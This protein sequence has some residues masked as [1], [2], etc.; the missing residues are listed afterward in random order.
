ML[1][2]ITYSL[3]APGPT[4]SENPPASSATGNIPKAQFEQTADHTVT[5][6]RAPKAKNTTKAKP[7]AGSDSDVPPAPGMVRNARGKWVD[8]KV[9][10]RMKNAWKGRVE[11]GTSGRHGGPPKKET[12]TKNRKKGVNYGNTSEIY[13]A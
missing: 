12:I 1:T 7:T 11:K 3:T 8:A 6:N 10:A 5:T 4:N 2:T 13:R 9:S